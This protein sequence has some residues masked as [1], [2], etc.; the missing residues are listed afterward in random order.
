MAG[1]LI[2]KS[3]ADIMKLHF[4][5]LANLISIKTPS[6]LSHVRTSTFRFCMAHESL[7]G[8]FVRLN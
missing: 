1:V 2:R 7:Q 4:T 5:I 8:N 6:E 3:T